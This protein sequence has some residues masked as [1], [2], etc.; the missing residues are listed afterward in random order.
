M[1]EIFSYNSDIDKTAYLNWRT[2]PHRHLSNLCVVAEGFMESSLQLIDVS[3]KDNRDKKAD[4]LIYAVLFNVNHSIEL[5]LKSIIWALNLLLYKDE[6]FLTSHDLKS[7]YCNT[8]ELIKEYEEIS[9]LSDNPNLFNMFFGLPE[10]I[11]ELYEKIENGTRIDF[12]RY[13][14]DKKFRPHFYIITTE[15]VV[16]D[17]EN[18]YKRF[19]KIGHNLNCLSGYYIE[20][21]TEREEYK[22][23][24][25]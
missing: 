25:L 5:Y 13:P 12:S 22:N 4:I 9:D 2:N 20:R 10:Y 3:L 24:Q 6:R 17:M 8:I 15:N 11:F 18:F 16:V 19:K 7:L 21:W 23:E 1:K 14:F